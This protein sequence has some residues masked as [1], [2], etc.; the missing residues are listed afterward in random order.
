MKSVYV[1]K[2][3]NLKLTR[4]IFKFNLDSESICKDNG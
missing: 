3:W 1:R 4:Y 2:T